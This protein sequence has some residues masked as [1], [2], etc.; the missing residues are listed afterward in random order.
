MQRQTVR[1]LHHAAQVPALK[2]LRRQSLRH[3]H[4][5]Q[6][7]VDELAG[8]RELVEIHLSVPVHIRQTPEREERGEGEQRD[9]D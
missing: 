4:P 5:L 6:L 9:E 8:H 7:E 2:K 1:R 3:L